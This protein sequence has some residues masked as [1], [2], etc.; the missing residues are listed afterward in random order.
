M[1]IKK[2][3]VTDKA[4]S[5]GYE[6]AIS[7]Q[8]FERAFENTGAGLVILDETGKIRKVNSALAQKLGFTKPEL[9]RKNILDVIYK[10]DN[11]TGNDPVNDML[12]GKIN[13]YDI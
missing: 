13:Q 4:S 9:Y 7:G 2:P 3:S 6:F 1:S 8:G 10:E 12:A 5:N 11:I